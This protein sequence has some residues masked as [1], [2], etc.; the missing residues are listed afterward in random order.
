MQLKLDNL[1]EYIAKYG[2][3]LIAQIQ[4]E[5][6]RPQSSSDPNFSGRT[7]TYTGELRNS[8]HPSVRVD[9]NGI[10]VDISMLER[11]KYFMPDYVGGVP[12]D[13]NDIKQ[14]IINKPLNEFI[15]EENTNINKLAGKI[16]SNLKEYGYSST[17]RVN[18]IQE[19]LEKKRKELKPAKAIVLDIKQQILVILKEAG[20]NT[21]G[22]EVKFI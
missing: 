3:S 10:E 12:A 18:F 21:E 20:F 22:K 16:T 2:D 15:N 19:A 13:F 14:W 17:S 8:L 1:K 4:Q 5:L 11:Y 6:D 7:I 9:S